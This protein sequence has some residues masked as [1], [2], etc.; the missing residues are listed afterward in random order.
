[1][2][3]EVL[4]ENS[5]MLGKHINKQGEK[6]TVIV[7]YILDCRTILIRKKNMIKLIKLICVKRKARSTTF[8]IKLYLEGVQ[9]YDLSRIKINNVCSFSFFIRSQMTFPPLQGFIYL[10]RSES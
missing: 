7:L 1:M 3:Y 8:L 10:Y 6:Q 5:K 9:T 2:P 4:H